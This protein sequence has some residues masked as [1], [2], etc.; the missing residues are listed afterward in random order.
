MEIVEWQCLGGDEAQPVVGGLARVV[1]IVAMHSGQTRMHYYS[2][3]AIVWIKT[4]KLIDVI[5]K[6]VNPI[7]AGA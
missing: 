3:F 1:A 2:D 5:V 4:S 7:D 6:S